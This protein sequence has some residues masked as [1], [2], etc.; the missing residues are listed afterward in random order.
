MKRQKTSHKTNDEL[1][2]LRRQLIQAEH[3]NEVLQAQL[4][5][6]RLTSDRYRTALETYSSDTA[7]RHRQVGEMVIQY[8]S[9]KLRVFHPL[10]AL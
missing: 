6:M 9:R 7:R 5:S 3:T 4:S 10:F 1:D 8:L 2:I